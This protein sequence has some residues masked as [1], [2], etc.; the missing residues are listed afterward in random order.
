MTKERIYNEL[1]QLLATDSE[2][3]MQ[4]L[5]RYGAI[6]KREKKQ[7]T[8][9]DGES[10]SKKALNR[11][12][13]LSNLCMMKFDDNDIY[14]HDRKHLQQFLSRSDEVETAKR[15]R[16]YFGDE[17]AD[18]SIATKRSVGDGATKKPTDK[19]IQWEYRGNQDGSI[20]G[21]YTTKQMLDWI[22]VGYF[23]GDMAVDVR[24]IPATGQD[25][26]N[27]ETAKNQEDVVND[28]LGDLEDSDDDGDDT[29]KPPATWLR[30]DEVDFSTY[31]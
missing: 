4:A 5:S 24:I 12:T 30:S 20:H 8:S 16:Q 3:V 18:T 14:Q 2:T 29:E 27:Q 19:C 15:K 25:M 13:E 17:D 31:L 22:K 26:V 10:A 7:K 23:V 21:P 28:L 1:N 11:L 9:Q 6:I